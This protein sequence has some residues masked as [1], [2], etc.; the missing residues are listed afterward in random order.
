MSRFGPP[1][2][3]K[4]L[5]DFGSR[6]PL[7]EFSAVPEAVQPLGNSSAEGNDCDSNETPNGFSNTI[8]VVV[9]VVALF[10]P[11]HPDKPMTITRIAIEEILDL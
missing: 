10:D 2:T 8:V 4:P 5:P 1:Q 3:P 6:A 11:E 7:D 9:V